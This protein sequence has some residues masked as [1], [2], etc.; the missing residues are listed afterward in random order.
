MEVKKKKKN[1]VGI[2]ENVEGW[3]VGT[4]RE[5]ILLVSL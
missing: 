5:F 3:G 1:C 2:K 4:T